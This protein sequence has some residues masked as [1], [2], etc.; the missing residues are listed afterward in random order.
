MKNIKSLFVLI[1]IIAVGIPAGCSDVRF[2]GQR[3]LRDIEAQL[4]LGPRTIGSEAHAKAVDWMVAGLKSSGWAVEVQETPRAGAKIRNV[5]ARR[6]EGRPWIILGAHFD[7]RFRADQDPDPRKRTLPVQGANDGASG[8]AVL[9]ELARTIPKDL[10]KQVCLVFLDAED[11]GEIEGWDWILGSE[12]Y[13]ARLTGKPDAV[14]IIDMIGDADLNIY[15]ELYSDSGLT[16]EIWG[17]AARLKIPQFINEPKYRITDDHLPFLARGI[18]AADIIDFDYPY[19]HTAADT[20][21][22]VS[23]ASLQA[24][25]DVLL[26][27]LTAAK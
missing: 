13:A 19:W 26:A 20:L 5:V 22:K 18:R 11:N 6:G 1:M 14:V 24:V 23:A 21:D 16:D 4:K 25:G 2:D 3:A 27:W 10:K 8:V 7:S 9:M 17:T 15:R 12:A